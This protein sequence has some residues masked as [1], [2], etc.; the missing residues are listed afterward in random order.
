MKGWIRSLLAISTCVIFSSC[1]CVQSAEGIVLDEETLQPIPEVNFYKSG[2][3]MSA[4]D[5]TD[6]SGKFDYSGISGGPG[7]GCPDLTLVF[8][9]QGFKSRKM[10]FSSFS[11]KDTVYLERLR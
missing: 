8:V 10:T 11:E 3:Q 4:Y 9:K 1:D 2:R 6:S 7:R 5:Q